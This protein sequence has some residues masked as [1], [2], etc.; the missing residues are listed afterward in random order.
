MAALLNQRLSLIT[1]NNKLKKFFYESN[2]T[3][4]RIIILAIVCG[5]IPGLLM[6][7]AGLKDTSFHRPGETFEFWIFLA[8]F[9]ILNSKKPLEAG[10]KTFVFFLISQPLIYLV[11]VPFSTMGWQLFSY[12]PFWAAFT[13]ATFPGAMIAWYTKKGN[14]LGMLILTVANVL[15]CNHLATCIRMLILR[16]PHYLVAVA[17]I[18]AQL[19]IYPQLLFTNKKMRG[20]CY[21]IE[22]ICLL[23]CAFLE[24]RSYMAS[25]VWM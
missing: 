6:L 23:V 19:Y 4:P 5:I 7:P 21:A 2:I 20:L 9:I 22:G 8:M 17:F 18:A 1:R 14:Y 15:L 13:V 12:Y 10:L 24:Y 11:Q 3:W 16:F 25:L